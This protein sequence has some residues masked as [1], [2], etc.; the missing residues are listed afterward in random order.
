MSVSVRRAFCAVTALVLAS[1]GHACADT[2]AGAIAEA[3]RSNPTLQSQRSQLRALDEEYVQ[4]ISAIRP[5]LSFDAAATY[6]KTQQRDFEGSQQDTESNSLG[7]AITA[8]QVIYNGGRTAATISAAEADILAGREQ[9]RGVEGQTLYSVIDAYCSVL[10]DQTIYDVRKA[11]LSVFQKQ[12]DE[13]YAKLKAGDVTKTDV[14]QAE[15]ELASA[16]ADLANSQ[17]QLQVSRA[18]YT[19]AVGVNPGGLAPPDPLFGLPPTIDDAFDQ[20]EKFSP[21]VLTAEMNERATRDRV[22]LQRSQNDSQVTVSASYGYTGP[23][24]PYAQRS[25]ERGVS[26]KVTFSKPI[27]T[28]GLNSSQIRAALENNTNSRILI[29][30]ARRTSVQQVSQNWN[31]MVAADQAVAANQ[32]A[33]RG[34]AQSAEGSRIEYK[35]GF[36]S[37]LEV[38]IE[39]ERLRDAQIALAQAKYS[40]Y[41]AQAGILNATGKLEASLLLSSV[42]IYDPAKNFRRIKTLDAVPGEGL[43]VAVDALGEPAAG[44]LKDA[45]APGAPTDTPVLRPRV[46]PVDIS[47]FP[48]S[49]PIATNAARGADGGG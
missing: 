33:I 7:A 13:V 18:A 27:F 3:Y 37:T 1:P 6:T 20:A 8:T 31:E 47:Q 9:L 23:A 32:D 29:E 45:P 42:P 35:G 48:A 16:R 17:G 36:R 26:G 5:T 38:L 19:A 40:R 43:I 28:G 22:R 39:E 24:E 44:K 15:S 41:V 10:R 34:A 2:L 11:V 14:G 25:M 30:Q 21:A 49:G 46:A 4:A 12:V